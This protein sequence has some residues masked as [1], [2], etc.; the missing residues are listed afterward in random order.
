[1]NDAHTALPT[2]VGSGESLIVFDAVT[3]DGFRETTTH[4]SNPDL[5][6]TNADATMFAVTKYPTFWIVSA[7]YGAIQLERSGEMVS[8]PIFSRSGKL[9]FNDE[10]TLRLIDLSA[11]SETHSLGRDWSG[12]PIWVESKFGELACR[13]DG[14]SVIVDSLEGNCRELV[15]VEKESPMLLGAVATD[16]YL[17]LSFSGYGCVAIDL[18]SGKKIAKWHFEGGLHAYRIG[19]DQRSGRIFFLGWNYGDEEAPQAWIGELA[20][21][22]HSVDTL[23]ELN[24]LEY[25]ISA[26]S[27]FPWGGH[28]FV[29]SNGFSFDAAT[30]KALR[31]PFFWAK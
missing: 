26:K 27:G 18:T 5:V 10:N 11:P 12:Q 25:G 17:I 23:R 3:S 30:G 19:C 6:A 13:D 29:G 22:G 15:R 24:E 14:D 20:V 21:G 4:F 28:V 2:C 9:L 8:S 31:N 7:Y 1:M 16:R